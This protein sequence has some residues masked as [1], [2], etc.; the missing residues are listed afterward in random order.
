[1]DMNTKTKWPYVAPS[2]GRVFDIEEEGCIC[3]SQ[4]DYNYGGL[5]EENVIN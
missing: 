5:D 3:L 4:T 1:M 2:S